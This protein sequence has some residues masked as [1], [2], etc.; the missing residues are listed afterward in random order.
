MAGKLSK[1]QA[2]KQAVAACLNKTNGDQDKMHGCMSEWTDKH[3]HGRTKATMK[4]SL[5]ATFKDFI[6]EMGDNVNMQLKKAISALPV[7][8]DLIRNPETRSQAIA[9]SNQYAASHQGDITANIINQV[10]DELSA[11]EHDPQGGEPGGE[12]TGGARAGA[13]IGD[14][15]GEKAWQQ[16]RAGEQAAETEP[17][18]EAV[19][20]V[21]RDSLGRVLHGAR[22]GLEFTAARKEKIAAKD[23]LGQGNVGSEAQQK[24]LERKASS[25][26][27]SEDTWRPDLGWRTEANP[28]VARTIGR[29]IAFTKFEE[30]GWQ[31]GEEIRRGPDK[32][33][34]IN[35]LRKILTQ[36][37]LAET[38]NGQNTYIYGYIKDWQDANRWVR[39]WD[40]LTPEEKEALANGQYVE[41]FKIATR[42]DRD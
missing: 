21:K 2:H 26:A 25:V 22:P 11:L 19:P 29:G 33:A 5:G 1:K 9:I 24:E 3:P 28:R 27:P 31:P 10:N 41:N 6:A 12:I 8:K 23:L 40:T 16:R 32:K 4:E 17:E 42:E 36:T 37:R 38:K 13:N 30:Q 35:E 14:W 18:G 15:E 7:Y 34:V 20:D 39:K